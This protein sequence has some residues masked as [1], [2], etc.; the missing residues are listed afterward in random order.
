MEPRYGRFDRWSETATLER[1]RARELADFIE[2]RAQSEDEASIRAAY[3][4]LLQI[5]PD[6][7]A[8]DVGCGSGVVT[9]EL[10]RRALPRGS[11]VGLD[12]SP[13]F[14]EIARELAKATDLPDGLEFRLGDARALPLA[15]GE[16][17][18]TLA[19]T[20]L[21]HLPDG[22]RVV[23]ELVRVTRPGGRVGIFDRDLD[24]FIVAH[25]DRELTRRI[26]L[27]F[28]DH[29]AAN[30]LLSRRFPGLLREAGMVDVRVRGF[31][32]L[33][34]DPNSYYGQTCE[35]RA[36]TAAEAGAITAAERDRWLAAL[37]E[38]QEGG[39]FLA[40]M[41]YIFCWG[42]KPAGGIV[43]FQQA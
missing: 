42:T 12:P 17:D 22:E 20:V 23:P 29:G 13:H 32:S 37:R 6:D 30:G 7:R 40:G 43:P 16:F 24:S 5:N 25:P 35:L 33:E 4:D 26:V 41:T 11:V 21:T 18:V 9:R 19:A 31:T 36:K 2:R 10:A 1:A 39:R 3:L 27:S 15:E 8:L 34:Q 14:L 28:A 38:E